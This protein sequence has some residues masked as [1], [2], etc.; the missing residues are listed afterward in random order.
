MLITRF[1]STKNI[2]KKQKIVFPRSGGIRTSTVPHRRTN[3]MYDYCDKP[4][5]R[6]LSCTLSGN[7][8]RI[9]S[10]FVNADNKSC[11]T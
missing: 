4:F 8:R 5:Y 9:S 3:I 7:T 6:I 10:K 2:W 11:F 1:E